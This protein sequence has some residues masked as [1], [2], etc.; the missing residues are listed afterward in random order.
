MIA[1]GLIRSDRPSRSP[2]DVVLADEV[3]RGL[4]RTSLP[5]ALQQAG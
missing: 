1:L 3:E 5:P 2:A 4:G